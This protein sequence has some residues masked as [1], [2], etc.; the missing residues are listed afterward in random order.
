MRLGSPKKKVQN[1][2]DSKILGKFI[3]MIIMVGRIG[4]ANTLCPRG[5]RNPYLFDT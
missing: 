3:V 4:H 2:K 1:T 5:F